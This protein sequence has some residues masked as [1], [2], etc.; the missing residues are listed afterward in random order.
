MAKEPYRDQV[1][2]ISAELA[3]WIETV[4]PQTE[5]PDFSKSD[6]EMGFREG[7]L[8]FAS[9]MLAARKRQLLGGRDLHEEEPI[10]PSTEVVETGL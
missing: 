10:T 7:E 2:F 1:P 4:C 9:I 5:R 3:E 6:K 8:H